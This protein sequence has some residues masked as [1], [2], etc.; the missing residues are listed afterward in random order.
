MHAGILITGRW[1]NTLRPYLSISFDDLFATRHEPRGPAGTKDD[2]APYKEGPAIVPVIPDWEVPACECE[3]FAPGDP[4]ARHRAV[5]CTSPAVRTMAP[6]IWLDVDEMPYSDFQA[7]VRRLRAAD[8]AWWAWTTHSYGRADKG[9]KVAVRLLVRCLAPYPAESASAVR[10]GFARRY[11][12]PLDEKCL[13]PI[14]LFYLP[15]CPDDPARRALAWCGGVLAGGTRVD[16]LGYAEGA[17]DRLVVTAPADELAPFIVP[18]AARRT[19]TAAEIEALIARS[20]SKVAHDLY[21][22]FAG[23]PWGAPRERDQRLH[24]WANALMCAYPW[25]DP[26]ATAAMGAAS[27]AAVEAEDGQ[28]TTVE[29]VASKLRSKIPR[30]ANAAWE[31]DQLIKAR[32]KGWPG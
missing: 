13:S 27:C 28:T 22:F 23:R 2:E 4:A 15:S 11:S 8:L 7:L 26:E 24:V 20:G 5:R 25:V 3:K 31:R 6:A 32:Q 9:S 16:A 12:I 10:R 1:D 30:A 18:D 14:A 21:C 29:W 17:K 19:P